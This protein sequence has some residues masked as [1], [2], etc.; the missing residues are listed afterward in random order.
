MGINA[1]AVANSSTLLQAAFRA[2]LR[3]HVRCKWLMLPY[4][5]PGAAGKWRTRSSEQFDW[6]S[7]ASPGTPRVRLRGSSSLIQFLAW[8]FDPRE[9]ESLR[10]S[11]D[12]G[13]LIETCACC[14]GKSSSVHYTHF[15]V[16]LR[17]VFPSNLQS[18]H[19]GTAVNRAGVS[20]TLCGRRLARR[21]ALRGISKDK[22]RAVDKIVL[23]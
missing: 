6:F 22:T 9:G 14:L 3:N 2:P 1:F 10:C 7:L 16:Q 17:D 5:L 13:Y 12:G 19:Y 11:E 15:E 23:V 4:H 20:V 21:C 8:Y 18:A